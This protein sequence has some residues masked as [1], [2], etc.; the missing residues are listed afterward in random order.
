MAAITYALPARPVPAIVA[1]VAVVADAVT[2]TLVSDAVPLSVDGV[3]VAIDGAN[4]LCIN[5][6]TGESRLVVKESRLPSALSAS[7]DHPAIPSNL[8]AV[9]VVTSAI[10]GHY[11]EYVTKPVEAAGIGIVNVPL[12]SVN[13]PPKSIMAIALLDLLAL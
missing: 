4:D 13:A 1:A 2:E 12:V 5:D 10:T 11:Y 7:S 3:D 9:G 8:V 6:Q